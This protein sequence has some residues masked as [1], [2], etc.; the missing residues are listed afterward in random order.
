MTQ[1]TAVPSVVASARMERARVLGLLADEVAAL[2]RLPAV[3]VA[4]DGVDGAGKTCLADEL[5]ALVRARGRDVVRVRVD[6]FHHPRAVRH[7][8]GRDSPEGYWADAF[9]LTALRRELLDPLARGGDAVVRT[10]VFDL[11]SDRPDP[12][13]PTAVPPDAVVVVDGVFLLRPG[14]AERWTWSVYLEVDR[15]VSLARCVARDGSGSPDPADP[16]NRRYVLAHERYRAAH[17]PA[18]RATRLLDN[19]DLA[20]PLLLR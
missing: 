6:D 3:L 2:H 16:L 4:V 1:P 18:G 19:T 13:A 10:K 5:G 11:A 9:D 15:A 20:R 14:L 7:R 8:Q 17:D 12:A